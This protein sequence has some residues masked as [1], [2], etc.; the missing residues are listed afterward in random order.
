MGESVYIAKNARVA[1]NAYIGDFTI[2]DE[3]AEIRQ[4]AFVRGSAIIGKNT[5]VGNSTEIKNSILFDYSQVPHYNYVG[6]SILGYRAHFGAGAITSNVKGDK[7]IIK[8]VYKGDK[9]DTGLRK[10][11]ALVG[12]FC[13][14][15]CNAVLNPGTVLG[16]NTQIYPLSLVRGYIEGNSIF[17]S[18]TR[19]V[20]RENPIQ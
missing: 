12:D 20:K 13:E 11:G 2:I 5:V 8:I 16:W 1:K 9:I 15:G 17:K 4:G 14:V 6:D 19:I 10:L 18:P 7:G 3:D